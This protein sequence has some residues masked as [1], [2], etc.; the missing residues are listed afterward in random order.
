MSITEGDVRHVA[1]L[2]RLRIDETRLPALVAELN[3]ILSHMEVLQGVNLHSL[4]DS[5]SVIP[6][7]PLRPD[8]TG[9]VEVSG[10]LSA[11]AP[12]LRDGFFL[13]PRLATHGSAGA[14]T[15][16]RDASALADGEDES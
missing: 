7:M 10:G 11:F 13:V 15:D 9:S 14:S 4:S 3:G 1:T 6:A 8:A 2:A 5:G 12:A 16:A